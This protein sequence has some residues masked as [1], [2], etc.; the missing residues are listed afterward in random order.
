MNARIIGLLLLSAIP[1]LG[2]L[3]RLVDLLTGHGTLE[4]H[5]RFAADPI[6]AVLHIVGATGFTTFGAL[7][8][9]P[10]LRRFRWHRVMGRVLAVL[11]VLSALSGIWM[12]WRWPPKEFDGPL[13]NTLRV[14]VAL[15]IIVFLVRSVLAARAR[16]LLAHERWIIRAYALFAGAGT[17]VFTLMPF[18]LP[19]VAAVRTPALSA[20]AMAAGWGINVVIAEV[21]VRPNPRH[22]EVFS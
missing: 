21:S 20:L 13:L 7:Q 11:G 10:S 12:V 5:E 1:F 17:Q 3:A 4:G 19:A 2:G 18:F 9:I 16:D 8:F 6:P 22:T 14:G 15:A